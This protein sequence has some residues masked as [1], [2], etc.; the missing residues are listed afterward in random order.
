MVRGKEVAS[1]SALGVRQRRVVL[2]QVVFEIV[3]VLVKWWK[4]VRPIL[5]LRDVHFCVGG[6]IE[7]PE[8]SSEGEGY[9]CGEPELRVPSREAV[10][11]CATAG[12]TVDREI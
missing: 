4:V 6:A 5:I 1:F 9:N 11:E 3:N 8:K 12:W 10:A 2:R 7:C